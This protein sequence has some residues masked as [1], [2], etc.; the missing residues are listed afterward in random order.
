[1]V[2]SGDEGLAE[3]SLHD[4]K[5]LHTDGTGML[6]DARDEVAEDADL[7]RVV[8][9]FDDIGVN[10]RGKGGGEEPEDGEQGDAGE[11]HFDKFWRGWFEIL[12]KIK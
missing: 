12:E 4:A 7:A 1:M 9:A 3:M 10:W 6:L 2:A 11:L 8:C 5:R